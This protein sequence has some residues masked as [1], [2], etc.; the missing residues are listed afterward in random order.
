M[1]KSLLTIALLL[2]LGGQLAPE[3]IPWPEGPG[4][5]V[6]QQNCLI[7]HSGEIIAGQRLSLEGWVKEIEKMAGW[8]SP[9]PPDQKAVL[10]EYLS[11]HFSPTTPVGPPKR[12]KIEL[13]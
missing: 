12:E 11:S 7:C 5:K 4:L 1:K 3:P 13:K 6:L 10:A 2:F 9:I 8:G